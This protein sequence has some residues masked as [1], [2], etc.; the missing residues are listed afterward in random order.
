MEDVNGVY[1]Q[2][3]IHI[4]V[5]VGV[6]VGIHILMGVGVVGVGCGGW[7]VMRNYSC[8]RT[9][10]MSALKLYL[11]L[12]IWKEVKLLYIFCPRHSMISFVVLYTKL[13]SW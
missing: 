3:Q 5:G 9:M 11:N 8:I 12:L 4:L 10:L 13:Y 7:Q 1:M 2:S 6:G